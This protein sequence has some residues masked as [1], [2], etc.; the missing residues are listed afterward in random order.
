MS[1]IWIGLFPRHVVCG[2]CGYHV[3]TAIW[4]DTGCPDGPLSAPDPGG[5]WNLPVLFGLV[6]GDP[7]RPCVLCPLS[8]PVLCVS[9][10]MGWLVSS[11]WCVFWGVITSLLSLSLSEFMLILTPIVLL[12]IHVSFTLMNCYF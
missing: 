10:L 3:F 4:L 11:G 2:W 6:L 7:G 8:L 5:G 1:V 12:G 9:L